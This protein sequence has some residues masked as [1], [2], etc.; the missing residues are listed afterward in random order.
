[1]PPPEYYEEAFV[2]VFD[3]ENVPVGPRNASLPTPTVG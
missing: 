3:P 1:M 2:K